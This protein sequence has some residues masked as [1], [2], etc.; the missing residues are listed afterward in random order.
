MTVKRDVR[1]PF[2]GALQSRVAEV[3]DFLK[4]GDPIATFVDNRKIIVTADVSE[5]DARYVEVGETAEARA[6][7][8][9]VE[10]IVER[11]GFGRRS[12][13]GRELAELRGALDRAPGAEEVP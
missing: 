10:S 11:C 4:V 7:L 13:L 6:C 5:F 8:E 9:E 12:P 1:A 3:G 2:D